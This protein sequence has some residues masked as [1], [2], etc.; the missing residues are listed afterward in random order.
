[1][2]DPGEW[3]RLCIGLSMGDNAL[4]HSSTQKRAPR[5]SLWDS[6]G[7]GEIEGELG[8][9]PLLPECP[10]SEFVDLP[11][12]SGTLAPHEVIC[13]CLMRY[14]PFLPGTP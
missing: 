8:N 11:S 7:K 14:L 2:G 1:M 10:N 6:E 4:G 12:G 9:Q 3:R 13:V 5:V